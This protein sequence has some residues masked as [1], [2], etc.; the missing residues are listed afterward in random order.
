MAD[1]RATVFHEGNDGHWE[2]YHI[3]NSTIT[4]DADEPGGSAQ[5]GLAVTLSTDDTV[6]LVGDG[7]LVLGKLVSVSADGFCSVQDGGYMELPGGDGATLT[8]GEAIVGDLG[9]AAAE[10]YIRA[11]ATG[12]AAELGHARGMIINNN[13]A[14]AV[15]VKL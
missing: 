1:P 14:T 13:T 2:T 3:D 11:V 6:G 9:T 5:V 8:L 7:E 15:V 10:G 4:Y 12:T